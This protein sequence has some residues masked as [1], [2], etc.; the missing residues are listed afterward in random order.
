MHFCAKQVASWPCAGERKE[1]ERQKGKKFATKQTKGE[2]GTTRSRGLCG[3]PG[4]RER[5][6]LFIQ[7]G[8]LWHPAIKRQTTNTHTREWLNFYPGNTKRWVFGGGWGL[9]LRRMSY[10]G[11][12]GRTWDNNE[13]EEG[14]KEKALHRKE[15][16]ESHLGR[17]P[18]TRRKGGSRYNGPVKQKRG[19]RE[20]NGGRRKSGR[21]C[22]YTHSS[23]SCRGEER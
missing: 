16:E 2:W 14:G 9:L 10:S 5:E 22:Q 11:S 8:E 15:R 7:A 18:P 6:L 12:A 21:C 20:D 1:R 4:K 17:P 19:E 3:Q 13:G 23:S